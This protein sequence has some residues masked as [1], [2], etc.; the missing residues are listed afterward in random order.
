MGSG[1]IDALAGAFAAGAMTWAT[2]IIRLLWNFKTKWDQTNT[3]LADMRKCITEL[4]ATDRTIEDRLE[5]HLAWHE[6]QQPGRLAAL[7]SGICPPRRRRK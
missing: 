4:G 3:E 2:L 7:I 6:R 5:R 1:V